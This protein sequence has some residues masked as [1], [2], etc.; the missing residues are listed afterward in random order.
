MKR[1][2]TVL[3]LVTVGMLLALGILL[4]LVTAHGFGMQGSIL[5]PMHIPVFLAGLTAGPIWGMALGAILPILNSLLT[6]MPAIY[7]NMVMMTFELFTY[8]LISGLIYRKG[9]YVRKKI[10]KIPALFAAIIA[11]MTVGRAVYGIIFAI[12]FSISGGLKAL[13]VW[14]AIA[15][16][17]P[18]IIA[19]ILLLPCITV[20]IESITKEKEA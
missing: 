5:L 20:A 14:G 15:T 8:G 2:K 3:R 16:G 18:G 11:A 12:L 17:I 10:G 7:P 9:G 6:G 13:T 4:P 1:N 19:Q